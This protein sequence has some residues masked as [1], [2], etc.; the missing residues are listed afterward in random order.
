ML[1]FSIAVNAQTKLIEKVV[2]KG[3]EIIIPYEK[4][5]L[6]NGLTVLV[7]EDHSDPIVYVDVTYHV[8]SAREQ[9][10][11]SGFAH[12]F[13][14]MMFQ[15]SEHVADEEHFKIV[16]EAGG[17]MNGTTTADRTN[18]FE[19]LPSNQMETA[20]WLESD[21]MGF[22]LDAVTQKKFEVQRETVKNERGQNYDNKPY[23][24]VR[25]KLAEALYPTTHPYSWIPI[26][27]IEDLN[28]VNVTD[29]KNFFLRWY[30][31]NNA[32]LTVAGDVSVS[33]VIK[34]AE[35]YFGSIPR[36]PEVKAQ[37]LA[38][39]VLEKDRY[40]SY[41]DN[42]RSPQI[43]YNF[44]TVPSNHPDEAPLDVLADIL[45][46]GKSSIF[47]QN[48]VKS[49]IAQFADVSHP[50]RELASEFSITVRTFPDKGLAQIDSLVRASFIEF[51]KRG[52]T[53]DDLIKYKAGFESSL[54]NSLASVRGKGSMLASFQTFTNNPNYII[55]ETELYNKVTKEDVL[56]VY[57]KYI[58]NKSAVVL[59]VCPKGKLNLAATKDNFSAPTRNTASPESNEY[60]NLVYNKAK[61]NFDRSKR[62]IP[63]AAT[64]VK[65]PPFWTR[66]FDNG[67]K[68]I[69]AKS[70]EIPSVTIQLSIET[71]HRF[72]PTD[73]SGE[74]ELLKGML[75][76][77]TTKHSAEEIMEKLDRLG[78]SVSF[79]SNTQN[80]IMYVTSLTKN[81]DS[82]LA[83]AEEMLFYPKFDKEE[84]ER[85]KKQNLESIA[86]QTTQAPTIANN[87]FSK[88]LYGDK[89]IMSVSAL[90]TQETLNKL[91]LDNIKER[92]KN[93]LSPAIASAVIVGDVNEADVISK[94][95]FLKNWKGQ[96]VA[97]PTEPALPAIEKTKIYI[98]NKE[99]APQTEIR[100]GYMALPF[101]A[102]GEY[103][104]A[105]VMNYVLGG[106][107]NSHINLNLREEHGYTYGARSAFSGSKFK[108][109]FVASAGVRGNV[110][111]S[112]IF[113]F[114]KEIKNYV[115]KGIT[116][117]ELMFTKNSIGQSDALNYETAWQKAGFIKQILDYNLDKNFVDQQNEIL[118]TI[119][120][121]DVNA[122]AKKYL[123]YDKMIILAVGDK[124]K[125][126]EGIS[127]LGYE[128]IE[129]DMDGN[130]VK[131]T[132]EPSKDKAIQK[133]GAETP[134]KQVGEKEKAKPFPLEKKAR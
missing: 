85:L 47:Y 98:V 30:G 8:G 45:A 64:L 66:N 104:K 23:G 43:T 120:K 131:Q 100:I 31:P 105:G 81:L 27:Y 24:L 86:N 59:S 54:V 92:Y 82:T 106:S 28:R 40:V 89:H 124:A 107:F 20:M 71:G 91:T 52:V 36:G 83:I 130:P 42:I 108:G 72:E 122:L 79:A 113:E 2:K 99:K 129:L 87:V 18:Y 12:F 14:H 69:G 73:K 62:P 55:K 39:P 35:K 51:E 67:L 128:T 133:E 58:K 49:Q 60:K 38:I 37:Q 114:M 22:L 10:G 53:D 109:P 118:K 57:N 112:S 126:Y 110:T 84:F 127:K 50:T 56:R 9:E 115:A 101:D 88:L 11:R 70:D 33:E 4:Y 32:T 34:M 93:T 7:H 111:D 26:G 95:G 1:T 74:L 16:T 123:P 15:G 121:A 117:E 116:D 41:E 19:V 5:Q 78:S 48:F 97:R 44:P 125:I 63:G 77:S 3:N 132:T 13:E 46:G 134:V 94:L 6:A 96:K 102:T 76:E 68:L 61:D 119:T 90:G 21:R 17:S 75:N 25:E 29:L 80:I 65:A 103:Y